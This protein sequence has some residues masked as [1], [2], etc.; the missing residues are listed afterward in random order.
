MRDR[1]GQLDREAEIPGHGRRPALVGLDTV[2]T[3]EGRVDFDAIESACI[4]REVAR[5]VFEMGSVRRRNRPSGTTDANCARAAPRLFL[6]ACDDARLS[7]GS[8]A[9]TVRHL[10]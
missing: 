4:A 1:L 7:F 10:E 9:A 8:H 3:V 6:P 5:T 2:R